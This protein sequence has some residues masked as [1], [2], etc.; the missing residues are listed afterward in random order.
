MH[1]TNGP[2]T[3]LEAPFQK[4]TFYLGPYQIQ[5]LNSMDVEPDYLGV[6]WLT[7]F[8]LRQTLRELFCTI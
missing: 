1:V 3:A 5:V 4:V 2:L 8:P 7:R 6:Y